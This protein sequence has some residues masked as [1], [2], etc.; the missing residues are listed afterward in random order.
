MGA[1]AMSYLVCDACGGR[2]T[3][4]GVEHQAFCPELLAGTETRLIE[5]RARLA[6]AEADLEEMTKARNRWT[7]IA[8]A[9]KQYGDALRTML[10]RT[11]A[12]LD[13]YA[14]G[15]ACP[16]ASCVEHCAECDKTYSLVNEARRLSEAKTEP[17]ASAGV[18]DEASSLDVTGRR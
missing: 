14:L 4:R 8:D 9:Q 12:R 16:G 18:F 1:V 13:Q 7:V 15:C 5:S 10:A 17:N 6:M 2:K 11:I 3:A